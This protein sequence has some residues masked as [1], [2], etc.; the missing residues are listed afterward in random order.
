MRQFFVGGVPAQRFQALRRGLK[1]HAQGAL[2]G[3]AAVKEMFTLEHLGLEHARGFAAAAV[4]VL[5]VFVP[6]HGFEVGI[7]LGDAR[8]AIGREFAALLAQV[9]LHQHAHG[10]GVDQQHLALALGRLAVAHEPQVGGDVGVVE[11]VRGQGYDAIEV[12]MLQDVAA[13]FALAAARVSCEQGRAVVH[14]AHAAAALARHHGLHLGQQVQREQHLPVA[15]GGQPRPEA[16][17][18]ALGVFF[19]HGWFGGLPLHAIG[20]VGGLVREPLAGVHVFRQGVAVFDVGRVLPPDEHV[21]L[22]DGVGLVLQLLAKEFERGAVV[23]L[24]QVL[25]GHAQDAAGARRGVVHGAHHA[26]YRQRLV[27]AAE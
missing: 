17:S 9:F 14:H 27:V 16:P 2:D 8:H 12:V 13:D 25:F 5:G 18:R 3:D 10:A 23:E 24:A 11:H 7:G 6:L 21:G 20:R 19:A 22:A 4:L 15:D 1:A 26:G